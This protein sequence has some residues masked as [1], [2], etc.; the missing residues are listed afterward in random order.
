M[1]EDIYFVDDRLLVIEER[2]VLAAEERL[3]ISLPQGYKRFL[4]VFGEGTYCGV[5]D[6]PSPAEMQRVSKE[7]RWKRGLKVLGEEE[8]SNSIEIAST[9][10]CD[11]IIYCPGS[12]RGVYVLPRHDD[13]IYWI[14]S[15]FD[16]PCVWHSDSGL[17]REMEPLKYFEPFVD[18][19]CLEV[20]VGKGLYSLDKLISKVKDEF[21]PESEL[22]HHSYID[23]ELLFVKEIS[24]IIEFSSDGQH[25]RFDFHPLYENRIYS[26]IS[27]LEKEGVIGE[28]K[29]IAHQ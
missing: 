6:I 16:D 28:L 15:N 4:K 10:D 17:V 23:I 14:D 2:E 20:I 5:I 25:V 3:N 12:E 27:R 26:L 29:L 24:A 19:A 8:I 1:F 11:S 18:R 22:L 13:T 7:Y 9:V 21:T